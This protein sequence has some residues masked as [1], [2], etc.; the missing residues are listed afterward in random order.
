MRVLCIVLFAKNGGL[1][2]RLL[3]LLAATWSA[4]RGPRGFSGQRQLQETLAR[5]PGRLDFLDRVMRV[6]L[7]ASNNDKRKRTPSCT[8]L[9]Q[10]CIFEAGCGAANT[11][12][13]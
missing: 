9:L 13:V 2:Y 4:A 11:L 1:D 8:L 12:D 5:L 10:I 7:M 6:C 3:L